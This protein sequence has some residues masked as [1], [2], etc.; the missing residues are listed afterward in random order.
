[1][2]PVTIFALLFVTTAALTWSQTAVPKASLE[3]NLAL[4]VS[5]WAELDD[6]KRM[7]LLNTAWADKA[8]YTDPQSHV[9]GREALCAHIGGFH[10]DPQFKGISIEQRTKLDVHHNSFR[11]GWTMLDPNGND[12][13]SG[14]DYGEFNEDGQIT[15]IVG[16]FGPMQEKE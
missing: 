7:D 3:E 8:T 15:K 5:A 13:I 4:Y 2:K 11:F 16:F 12:A 6:S 1:M 14:I 10:I 9:V